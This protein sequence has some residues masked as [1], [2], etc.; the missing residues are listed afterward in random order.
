M[1][2]HSLRPIGNPLSQVATQVTRTPGCVLESRATIS[3]AYVE[4]ADA[5]TN[6]AESFFSRAWRTEIRSGSMRVVR[7]EGNVLAAP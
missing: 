2:R 4:T 1:L 3:K 7:W 6:Q 5:S